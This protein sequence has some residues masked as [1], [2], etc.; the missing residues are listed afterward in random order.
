MIFDIR[1]AAKSPT[2]AASRPR[3]YSS[4]AATQKSPESTSRRSLTQATDSTRKGWTANNSAPNAAEKRSS[5]VS[6]SA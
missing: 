5:A 3:K 2:D 4:A 6:S 1:A